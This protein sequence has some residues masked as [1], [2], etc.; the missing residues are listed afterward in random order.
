LAVIKTKPPRI[1]V[2]EDENIIA[3]DIENTLKSLGFYVCGV[4]SSGEEAIIRVPAVKP[5]LVLM[6]IKLKGEINGIT[7]ANEI[8]RNYKVPIVYLSAYGDEATIEK[9]RKS[10]SFGFVNKPFAEYEL[11]GIIKKTLH[12]NYS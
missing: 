2:V 12:L 9:A 7:A 3:S 11:E 10:N 6:D 5:D 4:V 1:L 8:Y